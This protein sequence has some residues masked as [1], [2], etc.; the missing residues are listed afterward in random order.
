[1][2]R[3]FVV[4]HDKISTSPESIEV[5]LNIAMGLWG[6]K[7]FWGIFLDIKLKHVEA[8]VQAFRVKVD[9]QLRNCRNSYHNARDARELR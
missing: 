4:H 9:H 6:E 7:Q 8:R 2:R 5:G 1:M 3:T